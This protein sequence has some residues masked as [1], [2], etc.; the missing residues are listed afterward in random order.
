MSKI[1]LNNVGNLIDT[2]TS[3]T[4]INNNSDT[5][6][7]AFD[8]TL[9]RDGTSPN[10]MEAPLDMNSQ[11]II[12]LPVP[13]TANAPLRFQ[14]LSNFLG[15]GTITN[16]PAGGSA[17]D[18]L[19]KAS[20]ADFDIDWSSSAS[21]I[22]AGTNIAVTGTSP[23]TV[24]V[25][26]S[27]TF[28]N[29]ATPILTLNGTAL[30]TKT[31]TGALVLQDNPS[32]VGATLFT[33]A[34]GTPTAGVMTNV[35]GTAA[36]LTAGHVTTNANLTGDV[37][38]VGNATTL[39][40]A[41]VIAKVLT[42]YTSGAGTVSASDSILS[43][44]QKLNGN[45]ATN[46]N[47]TGDVTSVGNATTL[48][49]VNGNV[50]S[51]GSVTASPTL[52]VNAKGLVTAA[53]SGTITP[54]VGSITG[55]GTGVATA[56]AVNTGTAGSHIVNGGVLGTPSSGVA[57]NLTGTAA[58][59]TAGTVTTNANLT[60]DVTSSGN[61]TTLTN[62]PVIAKVLTGYTS[63]AGTVASTDTILQAIQ[64][65]NGN[66]GL[67]ATLASANA[68]TDTT[69]STSTSTGAITTLGGVGI[70]KDLFWVGA[71]Y[72]QTTPVPTASTGTFTTATTV[73]RVKQYGKLVH[74]YGKLVVTT[75]GTASGRALIA[76]PITAV[77]STNVFPVST[78]LIDPTFTS[79]T[80]A[81]GWDSLSSLSIS[82]TG[83]ISGQTV[84]FNGFYEAA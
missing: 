19:T 56:L 69:A 68:F 31:G 70:A 59:L 7:A 22:A 66:D 53:S 34:L 83:I 21:E 58:S 60:G 29:I 40:N 57:T 67:K 42:G 38:S 41:P 54:A 63:G 50:G 78:A 20:N 61:A 47:L 77:G 72:T 10:Q 65:L 16:I 74:Y 62:A 64:K 43:A 79:T 55:L 2:I 15:G 84:H 5:I 76:M 80:S 8:N 25:I 32:I 12:N 75:I 52:T 3:R 30:S 73:L 28:T 23:A 81:V 46:A 51:F 35:T 13:L 37:T 45:D 27:P 14:D 33:P 26:N 82:L 18:V 6:E 48:A 11:Q 44:I 4:T 39:T 9:S 36:G 1:T 49:T 71:A 17:N 24:S